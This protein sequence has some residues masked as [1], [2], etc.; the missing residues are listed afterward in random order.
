MV[1]EFEKNCGFI[2]AL[3]WE[4]IS[5]TF[6]HG[7]LRTVKENLIKSFGDVEF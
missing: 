5:D 7:N 1:F 4:Y 6:D 2:F 3:F